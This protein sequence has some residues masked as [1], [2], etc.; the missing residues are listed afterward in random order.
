MACEPQMFTATSVRV[1]PGLMSIPDNFL[2]P[3][4]MLLRLAPIM[5]RLSLAPRI[6]VVEEDGVGSL[7][8]THSMGKLSAAPIPVDSDFCS[9]LVDKC[10]GIRPHI[11]R[12]TT[13]LRVLRKGSIINPP[14]AST[15]DLRTTCSKDTLDRHTVVGTPVTGVITKIKVTVDSLAPGHRTITQTTTIYH[16][17]VVV[18]TSATSSGRHQAHED[19]AVNT[20]HL[21]HMRNRRNLP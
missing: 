18:V 9:C 17:N 20:A 5:D 4:S 6:P 7:R 13:L 3:H 16:R 8:T 10:M 19:V 15:V 11:G 1:L 21:R 12:T 14:R 2:R